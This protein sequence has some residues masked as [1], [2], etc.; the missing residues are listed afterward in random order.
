MPDSSFSDISKEISNSC[1]NSS[2]ISIFANNVNFESI[3]KDH[4][5]KD[6]FPNNNNSKS[7]ISLHIAAYE[8]SNETAEFDLIGGKNK[9]GDKTIEIEKQFFTSLKG[10]N[11]FEF[12]RQQNNKVS[13]PKVSQFKASQRLLPPLKRAPLQRAAPNSFMLMLSVMQRAFTP[14]LRQSKNVT[15]IRTSSSYVDTSTQEP[16]PKTD[17]RMQFWK[18]P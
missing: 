3:S 15:S 13:E 18:P 4:W 6:G 10:Q 8:N 5:K 1:K 16:V 9:N 2:K 11:S 7:T 17:G 14:F 12:P